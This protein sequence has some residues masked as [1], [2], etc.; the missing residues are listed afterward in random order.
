MNAPIHQELLA[1]AR[2][3]QP[4]LRQRAAESEANRMMS[5]ETMADLQEAGFFK[6]LQPTR[7]GGLEVHPNTFS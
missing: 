5:E 7:Y 6:M 4:V 3:L 2:A 1:R